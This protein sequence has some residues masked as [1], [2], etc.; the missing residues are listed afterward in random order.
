MKTWMNKRWQEKKKHVLEEMYKVVYGLDSNMS[1]EHGIGAK[2]KDV[3]ARF[4]DRSV[5]YDTQYQKGTGSQQYESRQ[6]SG[7][8]VGIGLETLC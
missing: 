8:G 7:C 1:G 4:M 3:L 6:D 2:R 5:E